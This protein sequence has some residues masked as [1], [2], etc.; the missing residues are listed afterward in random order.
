MSVP[1]DA[2][3]L[4]HASEDKAGDIAG[5]DLPRE[6]DVLTGVLIQDLDGVPSSEV[7]LL[8]EPEDYLRIIRIRA[9]CEGRCARAQALKHI[10]GAADHLPVLLGDEPVEPTDK[11]AKK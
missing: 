3:L 5:P 8:D 10:L 7:S 4:R 6:S 2:Y 9:D 1:C 11:P